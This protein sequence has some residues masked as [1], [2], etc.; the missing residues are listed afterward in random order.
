MTEQIILAGGQ[1]AVLIAIVIPGVKWLI[2]RILNF[3]QERFAEILQH[4][5]E[6]SEAE[7]ARRELEV[8]RIETAVQENGD[9]I[10]AA[11]NGHL[12]HS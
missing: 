12:A 7:A 3:Q 10:V 4:H 5:R 9:R 1:I 11:I 8:S 2:E 6:L